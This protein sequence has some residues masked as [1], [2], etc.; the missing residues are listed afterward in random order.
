[1]SLFERTLAHQLGCAHKYVRHVLLHLGKIANE[2]HESHT[3]SFRDS[4]DTFHRN[5]TVVV[6]ALS[7][8]PIS[9][10]TTLVKSDARFVKIHEK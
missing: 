5:G 8:R 1:M 9:P 6:R 7:H 2:R 4:I 3:S 10:D